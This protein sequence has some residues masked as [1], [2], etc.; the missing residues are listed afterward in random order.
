[1]SREDALFRAI[2][3]TAEALA[4]RHLRDGDGDLGQVTELVLDVFRQA[5]DLRDYEHSLRPRISALLAEIA[6][7]PRN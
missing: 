6:S 4:A 2:Q 7:R 5:L 1:M 3:P